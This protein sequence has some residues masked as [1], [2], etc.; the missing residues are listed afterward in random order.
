MI[1]ISKLKKKKQDNEDERK[2]K[3]LTAKI[4]MDINSHKEKIK[5]EYEDQKE[6][7]KREIIKVEGINEV[8][9][10]KAKGQIENESKNLDNESKRDLYKHEQ[11]K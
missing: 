8:N 11:N 1:I 6:K 2:M 5:L 9:K 3:Q 4:Q 10:I 7:N